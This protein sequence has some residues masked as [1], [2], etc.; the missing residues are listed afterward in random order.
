MVIVSGVFDVAVATAGME[1]P[2]VGAVFAGSVSGR[3]VVVS[4][5]DDAASATA[6]EVSGAGASSALV[7]NTD[8]GWSSTKTLISISAIDRLVFEP[9]LCTFQVTIFLLQQKTAGSVYHPIHILLIDSTNYR[10]QNHEN[11]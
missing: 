4:V 6:A 11:Q 1:I 5:L 9:I 2:N 3:A 8:A 10:S 7:A